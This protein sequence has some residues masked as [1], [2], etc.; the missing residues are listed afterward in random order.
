MKLCPYC[1]QANE[2]QY[3]TCVYC[4]KSLQPQQ[5]AQPIPGV[6]LYRGAVPGFEYK[7]PTVIM[8]LPLVHVAYGYSAETGLP[9]IA[10]GILA[11]GNVAEGVFAFGG[12]A[13][14][15]VAF[16][17][18]GV[19]FIALGGLAVGGFAF[20]GAALGAFGAVGGAA[21][22]LMHAVGG[23]AI[24]PYKLDGISNTL[25][26]SPWIRLFFGGTG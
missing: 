18:L 11:V 6:N 26:Q 24:A 17:G 2:D 25:L 7:S 23:L 19:G 3:A 14:G 4:G 9:L 5:P 10:K 20:G 16:G 22:S 13:F 8:G 1:N 21:L 15:V 12:V